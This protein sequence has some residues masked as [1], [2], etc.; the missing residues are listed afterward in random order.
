MKRMIYFL[1]ALGV[2]VSSPLY[3]QS[4]DCINDDTQQPCCNQQICTDPRPGQA[5][6][7]ERSEMLNKFNW[8][9]DA[10]TVFHPTSSG[11]FTFNGGPLP[12][13]NP[14]IT[15]AEYLQH[16]NYHNFDF[17]D[18]IKENL[19]FH[20]ENGWELIKQVI[21]TCRIFT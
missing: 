9:A 21:L 2:L 12:M 5:V 3:S 13:T 10:I 6:N 11:G 7:D 16:I 15:F 4:S 14:F 1:F 8:M 17:P 19:D 20:P 18:R